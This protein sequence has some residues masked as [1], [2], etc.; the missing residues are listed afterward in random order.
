MVERYFSKF[1]TF[2]YRDKVSRDITRRVTITPKDSNNP[3]NFYPFMLQDELRSDQTADM[4]YDDPEMDWFVYHA[5]KIIDPYYDWYNNNDVFT[6]MLLDKYGSIEL[7]MQKVWIYTN[8]WVDDDTKLTVSQYDDHTPNGWKKYYNPIWGQKA[9]VIAYERKQIDFYQNTN[10][11][12][13]YDI[14]YTIGN[15]FTIGELVDIKYTGLVVGGGEVIW[16]NSSVVTIKNVTGNTTANSTI[17]PTL[18]GNVSGT[19]ATTNNYALI[20]ESIPLDEDRFW[21]PIYYYDMELQ[22]NEARKHIDL[23]NDQLAPF[24]LQEFEAKL[25][26]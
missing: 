4:Y 24:I 11:I 3:Y 18:I 7:S 13:Q 9:Q 25:Q 20:K 6:Q 21:S 1:P 12:L 19:E 5:N 15:T 22:N 16:S 8:N 17:V 2:V 26:Q 14:E 10:R 23:V